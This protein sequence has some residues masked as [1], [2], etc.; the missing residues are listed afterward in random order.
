MKRLNQTSKNTILCN[1][2]VIMGLQ[3]CLSLL[4]TALEFTIWNT[5]HS[6]YEALFAPCA[7]FLSVLVIP[8]LLCLVA[9]KRLTYPYR[10]QNALLSTLPVPL[11]VLLIGCCLVFSKDRNVQN[12]YYL[13]NPIAHGVEYFMEFVDDITLTSLPNSSVTVICLAQLTEAVMLTLGMLMCKRKET[14][15][16]KMQSNE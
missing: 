10:L 16:E 8:I 14:E 2:G 3:V 12:L 1:L 6:C 15:N 4:A 13:C 9:R 7:V 11:F 5:V